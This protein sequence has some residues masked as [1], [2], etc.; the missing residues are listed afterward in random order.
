MAWIP[1]RCSPHPRALGGTPARTLVLGCEP[2][3][4]MS[5]DKDELVGG[6]SDPVRAALPGAVDLVRELLGELAR[7]SPKGG[8]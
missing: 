1:S 3:T 7:P 8:P 5:G 6:L 4:R 2:L